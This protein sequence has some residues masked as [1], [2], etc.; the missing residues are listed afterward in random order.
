MAVMFFPLAATQAATSS[1]Y[2]SVKRVD[3]NGVP[4]AVDQR[5]TGAVAEFGDGLCGERDVVRGSR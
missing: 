1:M 5:R 4:L 3:E 2:A